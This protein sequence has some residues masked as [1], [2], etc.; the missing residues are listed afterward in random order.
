MAPSLKKGSANRATMFIMVALVWLMVQSI[1]QVDAAVYTVG[2]SSGWSFASGSWTNGKRF[3][4][5][6]MLVFNYDST[7]HNVVAVNKGGY[8]SCT[9]P[10]G[11]TVYKSGKDRLKLSKGA[12]FFICNVVGHCQSGMKIAII[13]A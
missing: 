2:E 7:I 6:D 10:A 1:E 5:G 12:N 3:K 4:S 11:A 9:A 8:N 13:A